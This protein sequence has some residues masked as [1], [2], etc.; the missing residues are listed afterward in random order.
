VPLAVGPAVVRALFDR[1]SASP[2]PLRGL[3]AAALV[4]AAVSAAILVSTS[5]DES[6]RGEDTRQ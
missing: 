5:E 6:T 2:A 1:R 4:G 3:L